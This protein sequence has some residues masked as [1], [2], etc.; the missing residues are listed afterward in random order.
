MA[1]EPTPR[2][3]LEAATAFQAARRRAFKGIV[4][5]G[6]AQRLYGPARRDVSDERIFAGQA[7]RA[8]EAA[9][10]LAARASEEGK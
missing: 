6:T 3:R 9:R 1:A 7:T 4:P 5:L 8:L 2:Q 10:R